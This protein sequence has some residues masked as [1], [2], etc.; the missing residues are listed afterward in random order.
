[1]TKF[2]KYVRPATAIYYLIFALFL[3]FSILTATRSLGPSENPS[4]Y[5]HSGKQGVECQIELAERFAEKEYPEVK[6]LSKMFFTL[7]TAIFVASLTFSEK[8]LMSPKPGTVA[9]SLI[10]SAWVSL[11]CS[12][13]Y[14]GMALALA[15]TA[16]ET[17]MWDPRQPYENFALAGFAFYLFSGLLFA[18]GLFLFV[19]TSVWSLYHQPTT[20]EESS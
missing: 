14:C 13:I 16:F 17:V 7:V 18:W 1:M 8:I 6:D 11:L 5:C 2:E 3:I 20:I 19:V 10:V 4:F 9:K 15:A 12:I